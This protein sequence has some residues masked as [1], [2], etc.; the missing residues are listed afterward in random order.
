MRESE[1]MKEEEE[2]RSI[3]MEKMELVIEKQRRQIGEL[4]K[5]LEVEGARLMKDMEVIKKEF[6]NN[7][8]I[9]RSL[10]ERKM[11]ELRNKV[12][13]EMKKKADAVEEMD[14]QEETVWDRLEEVEGKLN[15]E[16]KKKADAEVKMKVEIDSLV[17]EVERLAEESQK[18]SEFIQ[19]GIEMCKNQEE[20][21]IESEEGFEQVE[22]GRKGARGRPRGEKIVWGTGPPLRCGVKSG[23]GQ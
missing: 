3:K 12:E 7:M 16:V 8:V 10:W 6:K 11:E 14:L 4:Q 22:K 13:A 23:D 5:R 19:K 1:K 15:A 2:A 18:T 9:E 17:V 21:H 20:R